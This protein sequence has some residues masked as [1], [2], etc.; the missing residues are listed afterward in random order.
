[1]AYIDAA[2]VTVGTITLYTFAVMRNF[3]RAL[4]IFVMLAGLYGVLYFILQMEDYALLAGSAV[5]L[6]IVIILMITT[7]NIRYDD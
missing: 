6:F 1:M 5:M 4:T 3:L 7:R 2:T